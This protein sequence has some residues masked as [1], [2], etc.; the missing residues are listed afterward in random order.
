MHWLLA[1]DAIGWVAVA[2]LDNIQITV[3]SNLWITRNG[4]VMKRQLGV[5][6]IIDCRRGNEPTDGHL[7]VDIGGQHATGSERARS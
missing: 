7:S 3:I 1:L 2:R 5:L 6:W 4:I